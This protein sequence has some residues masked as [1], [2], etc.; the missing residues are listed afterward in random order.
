MIGRRHT[1]ILTK[2]GEVIPVP[3]LGTPE[4]ICNFYN[5]IFDD[6]QVEI[7]SR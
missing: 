2:E 6:V 7:I 4:E 1:S 5:L 3:C